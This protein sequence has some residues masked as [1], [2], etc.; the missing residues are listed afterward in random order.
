MKRK[1][2]EK[3]VGWLVGWEGPRW[4]VEIVPGVEISFRINAVSISEEFFVKS[5]KE[6]VL[7]NAN[8]GK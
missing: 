4:I 5:L 8:D 3:D 2:K 7:N 6:K 1:D